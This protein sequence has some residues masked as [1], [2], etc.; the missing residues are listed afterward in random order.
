MPLQ[1]SNHPLLAAL[2]PLALLQYCVRRQ[3]CVLWWETMRELEPGS[4][5]R[6]PSGQS[7]VGGV[8]DVDAREVQVFQQ[9]GRFWRKR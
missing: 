8:D 9:R 5:G 6:E 1:S 3:Q 2:L 4:G 7:V